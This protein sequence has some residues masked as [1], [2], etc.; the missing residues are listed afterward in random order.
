MVTNERLWKEL[1]DLATT[2]HVVTRGFYQ[3]RIKASRLEIDLLTAAQAFAQQA[4]NNVDYCDEEYAIITLEGSG[5]SGSA[6]ALYKETFDVAVRAW[7][8]ARD[9]YDTETGTYYDHVE[10]AC[11]NLSI[12]WVYACLSNDDKVN[13]QDALDHHIGE[14]DGYE[15]KL[16]FVNEGL[17]LPEWIKS[18]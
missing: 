10:S 1:N 8:Y 18:V 4:R 14:A 13:A 12:A 7:R 11:G 6:V 16:D 3:H 5:D 2:V 9:C 17:V 15:W